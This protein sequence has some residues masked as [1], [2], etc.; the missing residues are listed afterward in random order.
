M[1]EAPLA[2]IPRFVEHK[3]L[4]FVDHVANVYS[5]GDQGAQKHPSR[6][7]DAVPRALFL[8]HFGEHGRDRRRDRSDKPVGRNCRRGRLGALPADRRGAEAAD[9]PAAGAY[10]GV[11]HRS[12][13]GQGQAPVRRRDPAEFRGGPARSAQDRHSNQRRRDRGRP[14]RQRVELPQDCDRQR[15]PAIHL[16][17]GRFEQRADQSRHARRVQPESQDFL[18]LGDDA[19]RSTRSPC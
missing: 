4:T 12:D 2:P 18:V 3:P 5:S 9:V 16:W 19:G 15:N 13:D 1:S 10:P 11:R 17:Q 7:G 8:Q 14:G 6:S